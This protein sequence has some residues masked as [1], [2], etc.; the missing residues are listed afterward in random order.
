MAF[1]DHDDAM[2]PT[3]LSTQ[4]GYLMR[5]PRVDCVLGRMDVVL[6]RGVPRP[7]W[8]EPRHNL[9][10]M[11]MVVRASVPRAIGRFDEDR[12]IPEDIEWV[13]K[14]RR[15]GIRIAVIPDI[16]VRRRIHRTNRSYENDLNPAWMLDFLRGLLAMRRVEGSIEE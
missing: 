16:V 11:S 1:L 13:F 3:K 4:I 9:Y 10:C 5:H 8:L 15:G 6:E 12:R 7:P 14:M 2:P